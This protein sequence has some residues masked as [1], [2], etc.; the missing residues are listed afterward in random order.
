M[1]IAKLFSILWVG[2]RQI[3]VGLSFAG[4]VGDETARGSVDPTPAGLE[5]GYL[6][7][8]TQMAVS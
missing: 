5:T 3:L 6:I 4:P 8:P 7:S 2:V 1:V